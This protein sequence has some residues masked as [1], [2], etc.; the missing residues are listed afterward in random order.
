MEKFSENSLH[1]NLSFTMLQNTSL[2]PQIKRN[3]ISSIRN[4]IHELSQKSLHN[5]RIN[6]VPRLNIFYNIHW[7]NSR[8]KIKTLLTRIYLL[9]TYKFLALVKTNCFSKNIFFVP[10]TIQWNLYVADTIGAKKNVCFIEM[11]ALQ[12]FSLRQFDHKAK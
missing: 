3:L 9:I 10:K 2:S 11:P 12:R 5:L 1:N 8:N 7:A 4:L 6:D